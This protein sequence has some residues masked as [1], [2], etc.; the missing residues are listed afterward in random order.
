MYIILRCFENRAPALHVCMMHVARCTELLFLEPV[1]TLNGVYY[2]DVL[3]TEHLLP[4]IKRFSSG[5]FTFQRYRAQD[6][7]EL[8]SQKTPDFIP[9]QP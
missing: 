9:L 8:L 2:H 5:H 1:A 3:L 7:I 6:M 4:A